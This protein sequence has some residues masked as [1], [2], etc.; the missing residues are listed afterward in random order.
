MSM[1]ELQTEITAILNRLTE[2]PSLA[3]IPHPAAAEPSAELR[4]MENEV[5]R[6]LETLDFDKDA[7]QKQILMCAAKKYSES[8]D[9]GYITERLKADFAKADPLSAFSMELT[10]KAVSAILLGKGGTVQLKL[11]NGKIIGKEMEKDA[12]TDNNSENGAGNPAEAG[13]CG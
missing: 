12:G 2:N 7:I 13:I 11:K 9:T 4:L 6:S 8:A 5:E 1:G 3:D 10:E